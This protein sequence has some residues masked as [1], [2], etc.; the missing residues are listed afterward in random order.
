[1]ALVIKDPNTS[2]PTIDVKGGNNT[3][4][5]KFNIDNFRA[6]IADNGYHRASHFSL[7]INTPAGMRNNISQF[8]SADAVN[9]KEISVRDVVNK[10]VFQIESTD[11]PGIALATDE[12]RR[13]GI[14]NFERKPY[15]PT[16]AELDA[17]VRSDANGDS[18]AFFQGWM[19]LITNFDNPSR[20][21]AS[22]FNSASQYEV[23][24]KSEYAVDANI[25]TYN[26]QGEENIFITLVNLYPIFVSPSRLDWNDNN[27]VKFQVKF[28]YSEWFNGNRYRQT[29]PNT[30]K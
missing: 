30:G 16:F 18:I 4:D 25:I 17:T 9:L 3:T 8:P 26:E 7:V 14:G 28:S 29:K 1:M 6:S 2:M 12:I 24:Y 10:L 19:Q 27:I 5:K 20:N 15:V 22:G 21:S 13:Y 23:A 11:L